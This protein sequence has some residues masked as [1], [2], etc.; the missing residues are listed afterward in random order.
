MEKRIENTLWIGP[1]D[2]GR[3]APFILPKSKSES[4]RNVILHAVLTKLGKEPL[5]PTDLSD[6]DD[7]TQILRAIGAFHAGA[8]RIDIGDAG[9]AMR[10]MCSFLAFCGWE[11]VLDGSERMRERPIRALVDALAQMGV[12]IGY[13]DAVGYPPVWF[14]GWKATSLQKEVTVDGSMSSQ[15]LSGLVLAAA[16]LKDGLTIRLMKQPTSAPYLA[17]SC[18]MAEAAGLKLAY[19]NKFEEGSSLRIEGGGGISGY[20]FTTGADWSSASYVYALC[21][22]CK[23][24]QLRVEGLAPS[25]L[26]GD[27]QIAVLMEALGVSTQFD[28]K[29]AILT[30]TQIVKDMFTI[31]FTE[32]PDLA[33]TLIVYC[34]A[35]GIGLE[36]SGLHTLRIKETDRVLA[37][38]TELSKCGV[39]LY[40]SSAG[41][42]ELTGQLQLP[43]RVLFQTYGDHRMAM[44]FSMLAA[45]GQVGMENSGVVS[46]SFPAYWEQLLRQE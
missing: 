19:S 46:K 43:A 6:A 44:A 42:Y 40:E 7:T 21:G 5:L 13:E 3:K 45:L 31:D 34:A 10:F 4:A 22:L 1:L 41:V 9:T 24:E 29:G 2:K 11:G 16:L 25:Q 17:M 12:N 14:K 37:L 30:S 8:H 32:C 27:A 28:Q 26:Q 15:Y 36:A 39:R 38:Q 35:K 18:Q 20:R 23:W 33:Q